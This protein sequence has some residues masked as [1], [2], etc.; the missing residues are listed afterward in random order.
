M[1]KV[2][3]LSM[4]RIKNYGSFLQAY[5]LKTLVEDLGHKVQFVDYHIEKPVIKVKKNTKN[6]SLSKIMQTMEENF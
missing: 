5:A 1:S 3:I 2:G 4:Q 6:N